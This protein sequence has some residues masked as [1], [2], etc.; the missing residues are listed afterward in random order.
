MGYDDESYL[1]TIV[2]MLKRIDSK[3]DALSS[4]INYVNQQCGIM[5]YDDY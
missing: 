2:T 3:D 5:N 1:A 4:I